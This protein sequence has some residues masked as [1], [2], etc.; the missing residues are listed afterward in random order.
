MLPAT[1]PEYFRSPIYDLLKYTKLMAS[2][3]TLI[4]AVV[5]ET[6]QDARAAGPSRG[7]ASGHQ[8]WDGSRFA[9]A[10]AFLVLLSIPP[11]ETSADGT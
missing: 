9:C 5:Y 11:F 2:H 8:R 1:G 6:G 4:F 3:L 10:H 7:G